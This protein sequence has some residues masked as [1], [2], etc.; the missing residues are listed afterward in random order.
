[1]K[2]VRAKFKCITIREHENYSD[3][4][5]NDLKTVNFAPMITLAHNISDDDGEKNQVFGTHSGFG[6]IELAID[7]ANASDQF[8]IGKCYYVDFTE[9]EK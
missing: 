1:M 2:M 4:A 9:V 8:K 5:K 6:H 3:G 7:N